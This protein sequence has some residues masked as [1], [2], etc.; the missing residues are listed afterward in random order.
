M[1]RVYISLCIKYVAAE[2]TGGGH[3]TLLQLC[4]SGDLVHSL[5]FFFLGLD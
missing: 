3:V 1:T 5:S 2:Q 4:T